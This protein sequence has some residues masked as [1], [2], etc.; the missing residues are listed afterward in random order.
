ML[1]FVLL[2]E[3]VSEPLE[4]RMHDLLPLRVCKLVDPDRCREQD[5]SHL[6]LVLGLLLSKDKV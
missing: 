2:L 1:G 3:A 4:L 6:S 5:Q